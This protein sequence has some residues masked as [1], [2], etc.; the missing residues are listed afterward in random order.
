MGEVWR[1]RDSVLSRTVAVKVLKAEYAADPSFVNRFR[2]E[3]RHTAGLSHPGIANV[4]DY[5]EI[6]DPDSGVMA[7]LVME[8]VAG[9][10]LS[11]VLGREGA[12]DRKSVV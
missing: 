10:P 6:D 3:A 7:Y 1:A 5:G 8:Y 12:L 9:E 11:T 4:F 2:D